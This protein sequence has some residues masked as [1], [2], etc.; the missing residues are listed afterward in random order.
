MT[1][2]A[3]P[4]RGRWRRS[5]CRRPTRSSGA[6]GCGLVDQLWATPGQGGAR[7]ADGDQCADGQAGGA[8]P[9]LLNPD[10]YRLGAVNQTPTVIATIQDCQLVEAGVDDFP[11]RFVTF[12]DGVVRLLNSRLDEIEARQLE[13]SKVLA[14]RGLDQLVVADDSGLRLVGADTVVIPELHC[15]AAA[16]LGDLVLATAPAD[17]GHRILL[18]EAS[19]GHLLDEATVEAE[20]AVAYIT[21]HPSEPTALI[22]FPMGQ[23]GC[24]ATRVDVIDGSLRVVRVLDEQESLFAGFNP[25]GT[26]LL[27]IPYPNDREIAQVLAWPSLA[28]TGRL[29]ATDLGAEMGI[30]LAACW[31]DE[32][33]IALYAYE[34]ALVITDKNLANPQR[35]PFPVNFGETGELEALTR[36]EPGRVA[37]KVWTPAG[38]SMLIF[39]I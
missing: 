28:E 24:I 2:H 39:E 10:F 5:P 7:R 26:S 32:E 9:A 8:G 30:G 36:L 37:A 14:A 1:S 3:M 38:R 16:F 4:M 11:H 15:D 18:I 13:T 27:V 6:P 21:T 25:T 17:A 33:R 34:D 12:R 23:D 22:E 35:V 20:D 19:T 29:S 31:I